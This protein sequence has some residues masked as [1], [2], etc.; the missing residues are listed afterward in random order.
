ME[1]IKVIKESFEL[2]YNTYVSK[3]IQ[4]SIVI[5]Y[6][7]AQTLTIKAYH[8]VCIEMQAIEIIE[9]Q[10]RVTPLI[11]LEENYNHGITSE[12]EAKEKMMKKLLV[13]VF[14]YVKI[15]E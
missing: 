3:D 14:K 1:T 7:D 2:W 13:E 12:E 6:S 5:N 11:K 4:A 8:K 9:G 15:L 10:S